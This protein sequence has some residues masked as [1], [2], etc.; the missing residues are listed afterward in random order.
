MN[1]IR[2]TRQWKFLVVG[3]GAA[4]SM[5]L[6][7]LTT[8]ATARADD[9]TEVFDNVQAAISQGQSQ[10]AAAAADFANSDPAHGL[11]MA[12][13]GIDN[14]DIMAQEDAFVGTL[15]ALMGQTPFDNVFGLFPSGLDPATAM[16]HAEGLISDGQTFF[17]QALADFGNADYVDGLTYGVGAY[18]DIFVVAPDLLFLGFADSLLGL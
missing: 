10:L 11:S 4:A 17:A 8:P 1:A 15:D 5:A 2:H 7:P 9:F 13:A 3:V 12:I 14:I 6:S 18:N 16:A